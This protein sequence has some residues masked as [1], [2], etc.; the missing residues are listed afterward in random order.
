MIN[1]NKF[2]VKSQEALEASQ[3]LA[4]EH[5]H[6]AVDSIHLLLAL[7]VQHDGI[8]RSVVE[9]LNVGDRLAEDIRAELSIMPRL[10]ETTGSMMG[11]TQELA[12]VLENAQAEAQQ[13]RDEYISTEHL[14]LSLLTIPSSA[15][16]Q[17]ILHGVTRDAVLQRLAT[18]RGK[19]RVETPEPESTYQALDRYTLNL[20]TL[21]REKKLDP[22]I[23]RDNEIRRVI[24]VLSRRTKNNPVLIGEAGTGK[25]AIIEGLAQRIVSGDV[26]EGLK[27]KDV[28]SLDLS[29]LL[30]GTKYRGEFE[31]RLKAVLKELQSRQGNVI[32]FIDELHTI[33]GAGAIEGAMDAAN[34]LKPALARGELRAI[35]ATTIKEYQK[36]IEKDPAL[37]RRFQPVFVGEPTV[38]DAIAILR[39][40]K[41]KYE[42][43]H[44]VRI[45]DAALVAAAELSSRYITDRFLPDK[46]IDLIDEA[47][48]ALR[49]EVESMPE[50]LDILKRTILKREIEV[51]AL[52]KETDE[53]S[54]KRLKEIEKELASIK[55]Q[56]RELELRWQHERSIISSLREIQSAI[57]KANQEAEIAERTG[58]L[59]KVAEIRYGRIPELQQRYEKEEAKLK[60]LEVGRRML[61]EE[62][63]EEDV[64]SVVA[65]WT[66]IPVL[67]L[68]QTEQEKLQN[69]EEELHK[70]VIGQGE[71]VEG[72]A[73]ALR[74]ARTGLS[75]EKRPWGSFLFL[76]PTG[77]G[78][79]ELAK[80]LAEYLFNDE[81]ALVR[82]DMS[83]YM[84]RHAVSRLVGS[85]PGYIGH[86]EG[87]QLTEKIRR[88]PYS[89]ILFD[90]IEKAHPDVFNTL[91]Q[92]LDDGRLTDGKGR[93]VNFKNTIII[94]TS[95]LGNAM[96]KKYSIGFEDEPK[97]EETQSTKRKEEVRSKI[98]GV[99]SETFRPE[100]LNRLDEIIIFEPLV[101]AQMKQIVDL[102]LK[103]VFDRLHRQDKE[104]I[105]K[106]G[107][108]TY[109]AN[110]GYDEQFG[111]R[112]LK[113][114]IEH[115]M[116]NPIAQLLLTEK[117]R[118]AKKITVDWDGSTMTLHTH[119]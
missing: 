28:L 93:V 9:Q 59:T 24:Q 74:R 88:R 114:L 69:V 45:T 65:N 71:A 76:G 13:L 56:E 77:V 54:R 16:Q 92:I 1:I 66:G 82:M 111:A 102:Q 108:K 36:Y 47:T 63:T 44:G 33:V 81:N 64:A 12:K 57:D 94:L 105:V 107:A 49:M 4:T 70:R 27:G 58:E 30:A 40:I 104:L 35:G 3:K 79:T 90:E 60:R 95:N 110:H 100:F 103:R 106:D 32:L 112:P 98:M 29:A 87:G 73:N 53:A 26:P 109:L 61:K 17:L 43:H 5:K 19:T 80:T 25:T 20:T 7:V 31:Q 72:I 116:V 14:L 51:E 18:I 96:I 22:I 89:V 113:R 6:P 42:I 101:R 23:G 10:R 78:K 67:R 119:A 84:E 118:K 50:E 15:Q 62:V 85:P 99:L 48:A 52:K 8:V 34:M 75:E 2:T 115:A 46:A 97:T 39:G 91:L 55:E 83:E 11:L 21:A 117:G 86:D 38:E 68:M 37:E 41:E